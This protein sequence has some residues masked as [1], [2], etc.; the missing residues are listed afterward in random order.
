MSAAYYAPHESALD[1]STLGPGDIILTHGK[2]YVGEAIRTGER[3]RFHGSPWTRVNHAA[4]VV[5]AQGDL[6]EMLA[7]GATLSHI[8]KYDPKEYWHIRC[9]EPEKGPAVVAYWQ[10]CLE[11]HVGY[12]WYNA[13]SDGFVCLTGSNVVLGT[14]GRLICSGM[15][16]AGYV[17]AGIAGVEEWAA[18][19]AFVFPTELGMKFG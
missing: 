2:S 6:I 5:N 15:V 16:A 12:A 19:P 7:K 14:E 10:W 4:G 11:H 18:S 13:V 17:R 9:P 3:I 1:L 8:S